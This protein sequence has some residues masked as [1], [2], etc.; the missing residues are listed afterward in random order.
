MASFS[1]LIINAP[2]VEHNLITWV[3][4]GYEI[5]FVIHGYNNNT[6]IYL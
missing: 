2:I 1:F 6:T 5:T 3:F 4:A